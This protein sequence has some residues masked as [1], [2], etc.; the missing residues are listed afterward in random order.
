MTCLCKRWILPYVIAKHINLKEPRLLVS[1]FYLIPRL[2]ILAWSHNKSLTLARVFVWLDECVLSRLFLFVQH[3]L[4]LSYVGQKYI[5]F[6][7][8]L[9]LFSRFSIVLI[10]HG[11]L[12]IVQNVAMVHR[13]CLSLLQAA[14]LVPQ[15]E[16]LLVFVGL[17]LFILW[18]HPVSGGFHWASG[19]VQGVGLTI[20]WLFAEDV[21]LLL[22]YRF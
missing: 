8:S 22:F 3:V 6:F 18:N 11:S 10:G 20:H 17:L 19:L 1:F 15:L 7:I 21:S 12:K 9:L 13:C 14:V 5:W 16:K 2:R 4:F